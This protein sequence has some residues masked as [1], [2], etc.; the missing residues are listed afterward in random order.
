MAVSLCGSGFDTRLYIFQNDQNTE[1]ACNDD[2]CNFQSEVMVFLNPGNTYY[3]VVDGYNMESGAY[4]INV[5]VSVPCTPDFAVSGPGVWTGTTCGAG[6][7]S[8]LRGSEDHV[9]AVSIPDTG[10][11][12]F[13][14]CGY[15]E[16]WDTYLYVGTAP[17]SEDLGSNDDYCAPMSQVTANIPAPGTY[18][19]T[20][21]GF[22]PDNC[23]AY[24]LSSSRHCRP[25]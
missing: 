21:E 14:L 23:G 15:S 5:T 12:I 7:D 11:W 17:C 2:Y 18:Y 8:P 13:S 1:I 6:N 20:I 3:F 25:R 9:Y 16:M 10:N 4:V 24:Q 19:V 22:G